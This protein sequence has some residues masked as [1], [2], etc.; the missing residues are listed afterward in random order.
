MSR[1][2]N[3]SGRKQADTHKALR[4][5]ERLAALRDGRKPGR[6]GFHR[7]RSKYDRSRDRKQ[8]VR[9]ADW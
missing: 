8:A 4:R 1:S 5:K 7:D 9:N 6:G 2:I 3:E